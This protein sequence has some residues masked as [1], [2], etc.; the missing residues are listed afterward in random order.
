MIRIFPSKVEI[1]LSYDQNISLKMLL[2]DDQNIFLKKLSSEDQNTSLKIVQWSEYFPQ[3][4]IVWQSEYFLRNNIVRW[5]EEPKVGERDDCP[6]GCPLAALKAT[7]LD[8]RCILSINIIIILYIS[9]STYNRYFP[10]IYIA[11]HI[12]VSINIHKITIICMHMMSFQ[13]PP[14]FYS[15]GQLGWRHTFRFFFTKNCLEHCNFLLMQ[16]IDA[17]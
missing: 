13:I 6:P 14:S 8:S 17:D 10:S 16:K 11:P 3:H 1:V 7:T 4:N 2:S 9:I 5:W 12:S 15:N